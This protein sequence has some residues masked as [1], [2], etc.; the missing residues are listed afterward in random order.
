MKARPRFDFRRAPA[1]PAVATIH[2][3]DP[4][5]ALIGKVA[6]SGVRWRA[7]A[8]DERAG[9]FSVIPGSYPGEAPARA[10]LARRAAR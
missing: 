5:G 2:V 6:G 9:E 1:R 4:G 3:H 8:W 7:W 10:A